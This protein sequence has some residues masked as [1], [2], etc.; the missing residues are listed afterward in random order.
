MSGPSR[1]GSAAQADYELPQAPTAEANGK[2]S[3]EFVPDVRVIR[4]RV[5]RVLNLGPYQS[6]EFQTELEAAPDPKF[7]ISENT[8]RLQR[9]TEILVDEACEAATARTEEAP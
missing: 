6:K 3:S 1:N 9:R 2:G 7:S 4:T 8:K 5:R